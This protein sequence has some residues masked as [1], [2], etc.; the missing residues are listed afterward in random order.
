MG[1]IFLPGKENL[2]FLSHIINWQEAFMKHEQDVPFNKSVH[3]F[4][5]SSKFSGFFSVFLLSQDPQGL[6]LI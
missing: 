6:R 3:P 1:E 5:S 4:L 2:H